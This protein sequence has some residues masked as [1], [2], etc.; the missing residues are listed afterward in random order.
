MSGIDETK[1][2]LV[3]LVVGRENL[4]VRRERAREGLKSEGVLGKRHR[5]KCKIFYQILSV[6]Y[7]TKICLVDFVD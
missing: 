3:A 1:S 7:F 5:N 6:N 2:G 4:R